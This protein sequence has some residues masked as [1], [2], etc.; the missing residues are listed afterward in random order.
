MRENVHA[1]KCCCA[2]KSCAEMLARKRRRGN[3]AR[4]NVVSWMTAISYFVS[5]ISTCLGDICSVFSVENR[6]PLLLVNYLEKTDPLQY[7]I[8]FTGANF[9][10]EHIRHGNTSSQKIC[11]MGTVDFVEKSVYFFAS[12]NISHY[13]RFP[14]F[15]HS[16]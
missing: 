6:Q 13:F 16:S 1:R 2:Q 15:C 9:H 7:I 8:S 5:I 14:T 11:L 3:V 10:Y 4:G 12:N